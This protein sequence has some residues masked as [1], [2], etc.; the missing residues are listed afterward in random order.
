MLD[1][2]QALK[3]KITIQILKNSEMLLKHI[4]FFQLKSQEQILIFKE[5]KNL[6]YTKLMLKNNLK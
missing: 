5:K 6:N 2:L 1:L 3:P 4:K